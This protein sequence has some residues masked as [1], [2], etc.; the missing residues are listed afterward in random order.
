M[1]SKGP[2]GM[3]AGLTVSRSSNRV[4]IL[5]VQVFGRRSMPTTWSPRASRP[6]PRFVPICPLEPVIST[7][8][9]S[10]SSARGADPPPA[11]A[12]RNRVSVKPSRRSITPPPRRGHETEVGRNQASDRALTQPYFSK[13]VTTCPAR[14]PPDPRRPRDPTAAGRPARPDRLEPAGFADRGTVLVHFFVLAAGRVPTGSAPDL[15]GSMNSARTTRVNESGG[16]SR[17]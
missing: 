11:A 13:R 4:S 7:R 10:S 9:I 1:A 6:N 2:S 3:S 14:E 12:G 5:S 17:E 16:R 8:I 15:R